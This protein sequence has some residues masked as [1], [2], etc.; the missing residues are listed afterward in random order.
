[1]VLK[2]QE[3]YKQKHAVFKC[4]IC[5]QAYNWI[6]QCFLPYTTSKMLLYI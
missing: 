5:K 1:M 4:H 3:K 2:T 6:H